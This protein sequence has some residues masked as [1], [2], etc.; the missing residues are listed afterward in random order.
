[1]RFQVAGNM[2]AGLGDDFRSA[3]YSALHT[4]ITGEAVEGPAGNDIPN[5][6]DRVT[7][8]EQA[9]KDASRHVK[10]RAALPPQFAD[11]ASDGGS[12]A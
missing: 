8:I 11:E 4:P 6:T 1:M 2:A 12:R 7:D 3:L 9:K 5:A 10:I